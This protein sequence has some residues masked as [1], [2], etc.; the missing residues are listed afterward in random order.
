MQKTNQCHILVLFISIGLTRSTTLQCFLYTSCSNKN[1]NNEGRK[2]QERRSADRIYRL[3]HATRRTRTPK[4]PRSTETTCH[5]ASKRMPMPPQ[6]TGDPL[7]P[8]PLPQVQR[9]QI[10]FHLQGIHP[11]YKS[12][13]PHREHILL[14]GFQRHVNTIRHLAQWWRRSI[15]WS[16]SLVWLPSLMVFLSLN[17]LN[18]GNNK[19]HASRQVPLVVGSQRSDGPTGTSDT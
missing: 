9:A 8:P 6:H 3:C 19:W 18:P 10:C 2:R 5:L 7:L 17:L 14:L 4:P 11:I 16:G 13:C 15:P 12:T 1:Q